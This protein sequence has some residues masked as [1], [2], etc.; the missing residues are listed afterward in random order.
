MFNFHPD[1]GQFDFVWPPA[2]TMRHTPMWALGTCGEPNEIKK[3]T[4]PE[5][6]TALSRDQVSLLA[7]IPNPGWMEV[8]AAKSRTRATLHEWC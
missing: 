7:A 2:R 8:R 4:H 5:N 1:G 6:I 3:N